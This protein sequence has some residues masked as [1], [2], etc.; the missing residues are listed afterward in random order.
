MFKKD[1]ALILIECQNEF[2]SV[3]GGLYAAIK[4]VLTENNV[5]KN[6][7]ETLSALR[8][9]CNI[10]HVPIAFAEGYPEVAKEPY[11]IMKGVVD[12]NAFI[13]NSKAA[14]FYAE[15][16]PQKGDIVAEGKKTLSA[17]NSSN[18]DAILRAN[19]IKTIAIVG[20]LTNVCVESTARDAFDLGYN[21][22]I[23]SDCT[24]ATS[25]EEQQYAVEKIFP[26]FAKVVDHNEF[27]DLVLEEKTASTATQRAYY[28]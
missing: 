9:N 12:G 15:L 4:E 26:L 10:I 28:N 5:L 13:K 3:D 27:I 19:E 6:I 2:C 1:T 7:K 18:L 8:G 25:K 23:L 22:H 20:F 14:E 21:V 11:G 24:A 16:A 17:F